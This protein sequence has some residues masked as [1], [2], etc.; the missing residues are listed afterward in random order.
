MTQT[1]NRSQSGHLSEGLSTEL[2]TFMIADVRGYTRFTQERGDDAGAE[3]ASLR[4]ASIPVRDQAWRLLY[5]QQFDVI[6]RL[7]C[8]FGVALGEVE[9][10]TQTV[11]ERAHRRMGEVDQVRHVGV[12]LRGIAVRVVAE[13]WRWQRV[14]R[15]GRWLLQST[16]EASAPRPP[17]PEQTTAAA[18]LQGRVGAVLNRMNRKLRE[19]LVLVDIEE[20]TPAEAAVILDIP[21]N[22]VRSRR[23]LARERFRQLWTGAPGGEL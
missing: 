13:H 16:V 15:L 8:R 18:Q 19:V 1:S 21:V 4:S 12:W 9:D 11:F 10:V 5:Q 6:Y 14:R 2:R 7:V 23:R 3:L 17:T 20:C 22:T